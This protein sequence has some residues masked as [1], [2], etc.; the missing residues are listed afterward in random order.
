[1]FFISRHIVDFPEA[2]SPVIPISK[3]LEGLFISLLVNLDI[4]VGLTSLKI[5]VGQR[6]S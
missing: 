6:L 4:N 2:D 3:R 1:M 5:G